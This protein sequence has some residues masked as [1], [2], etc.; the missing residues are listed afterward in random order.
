MF[1]I[2]GMFQIARRRI[3]FAE[4]ND[5]GR[6]HPKASAQCVQIFSKLQ[7]TPGARVSGMEHE[8]V[9][10]FPHLPIVSAIFTSLD[11]FLCNVSHMITS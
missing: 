10:A 7:P 2:G 9:L 6:K 1:D 3:G 8:H 4:A 5:I 11:E